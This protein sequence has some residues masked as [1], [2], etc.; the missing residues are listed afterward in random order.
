MRTDIVVKVLMWL[1]FA[2]FTLGTL[3]SGFTSSQ[4][5]A[6]PGDRSGGPPPGDRRGG[7]PEE[8]ITACDGLNEGEVCSFESPRGDLILGTCEMTRADLK[9]CVPQGGPPDGP[10]GPDGD[11][12][13]PAED[14][15]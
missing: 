9:A 5:V 1:L 13:P 11:R 2:V 14:R 8:A 12:P 15:E 10:S 3:H 4:A 6:Q 7:P